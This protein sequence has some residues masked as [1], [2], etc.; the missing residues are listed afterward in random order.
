MHKELECG[1]FV[2]AQ[3]CWGKVPSQVPATAYE[4]SSFQGHKGL[5]KKVSF[6]LGI[7]QTSEL[8]SVIAVIFRETTM[9]VR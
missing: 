4:G 9:G 3:S 5:L 7:L 8:I 2:P 1:A 6:S